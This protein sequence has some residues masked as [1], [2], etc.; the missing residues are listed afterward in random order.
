MKIDTGYRD[1]ARPFNDANIYTHPDVNGQT[2]QPVTRVIPN[3]GHT[4]FLQGHH[5]DSPLITNLCSGCT[6][7]HALREGTAESGKHRRD[8]LHP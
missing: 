4:Y 1:L 2:L 5:P 8:H 3:C 7:H 6:N